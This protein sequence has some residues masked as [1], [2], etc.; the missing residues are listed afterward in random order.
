VRHH[1]HLFYYIG[2][3][4]VAAADARLRSVP[5]DYI[6]SFCPPSQSDRPA[7]LTLAFGSITP[8]GQ[9]SIINEDRASRD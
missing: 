4:A 2:S 9:C 8:T 5:C 7:W 3:N 1:G 6:P